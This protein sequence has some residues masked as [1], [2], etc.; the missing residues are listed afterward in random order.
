MKGRLH[1]PCIHSASFV[2]VLVSLMD[3]AFHYLDL[4]TQEVDMVIISYDAKF[5]SVFHFLPELYM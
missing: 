5:V 3:S 4:A 1:F 2:A